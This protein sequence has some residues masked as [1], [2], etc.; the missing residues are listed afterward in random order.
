MMRV[1]NCRVVRAFVVY[2]LSQCSRLL[3]LLRVVANQLRQLPKTMVMVGVVILAPRR[4]KSIPH[5]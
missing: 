2:L 5:L 3:S 1:R 4:E